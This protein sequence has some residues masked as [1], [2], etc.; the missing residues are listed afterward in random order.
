[1]ETLKKYLVPVLLIVI[2]LLA[3]LLIFSLSHGDKSEND[4]QESML[5]DSI[6]KKADQLLLETKQLDSINDKADMLLL[7][8]ENISDNLTVATD[9]VIDSLES[10]KKIAKK[11]CD[12]KVIKNK[13]AVN[14]KKVV[15]K[16]TITITT[17]DTAFVTVKK[18]PVFVGY[19]DE[20]YVT[21]WEGKTTYVVP[22]SLYNLY[23]GNEV[24]ELNKQGSRQYF[25][26]MGGYYI[27]QTPYRGES[28][29]VVWAVYIGSG[30]GYPA[31]LPHESVKKTILAIEGR[32]DGKPHKKLIKRLAQIKVEPNGVF[33]K[34]DDGK[35]YYG[36]QY[37][38][39]IR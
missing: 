31:Y 14:N 22:L 25:K 26:L 30:K 8:H 9:I 10:L 37:R 12:E 11:C 21:I 19:G 17:K 32:I 36:Y 24:P 4:S 7:D 18:E 39:I 16:E 27:Y 2:L 33:V 20:A 3:G 28:S 5:L 29:E 34:A 13:K 6:N 38:H 35:K 23:G 15:V 1:M